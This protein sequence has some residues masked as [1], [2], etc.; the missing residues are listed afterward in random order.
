MRENKNTHSASKLGRRLLLPVPCNG[1]RRHH[2]PP[3][4][5]C[6]SHC[7]WYP[8]VVVFTNVVASARDP[9]GVARRRGVGARSSVVVE[10]HCGRSSG[11]PSAG[12]LRHRRLLHAGVARAGAGSS[13]VVGVCCGYSSYSWG[14]L[15]GH[16]VIVVDCM[17]MRSTLRTVWQPEQAV[18]AKFGLTGDIMAVAWQ[19]PNPRCFLWSCEFRHGTCRGF[20]FL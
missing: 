8:C 10:L 6:C 7:S 11:G 5:P 17:H 3:R 18:P 1:R 19:F 4:P 16:V 9:G 14:L 12:G 20:A 13:I 2:C 15:V